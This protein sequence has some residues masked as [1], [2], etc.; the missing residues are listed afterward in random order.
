M[1]NRTFLL[2]QNE[3]FLILIR[4]YI[5]I[6]LLGRNLIIFV[7]FL[8]QIYSN[9]NREIYFSMAFSEPFFSSILSSDMTPSCLRRQIHVRD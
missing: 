8:S 1:F 9:E 2:Q 6:I 5:I 4:L 3:F 7:I